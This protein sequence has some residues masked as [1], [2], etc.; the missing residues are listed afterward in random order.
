VQSLEREMRR[1]ALQGSRK[2]FRESMSRD[3]EDDRRYDYG[4]GEGGY[5]HRIRGGNPYRSGQKRPSRRL[6]SPEVRDDR[7]RLG[8]SYER[9]AQS[10]PPS[11]RYGASAPSPPQSAAMEPAHHHHQ[12]VDTQLV[13]I[14][15]ERMRP[16]TVSCGEWLTHSPC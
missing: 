7:S 8:M 4:H 15:S 10:P 16:R 12:R 3:A 11:R 5:C 13:E 1:L 6:P 9:A 14:T 2:G